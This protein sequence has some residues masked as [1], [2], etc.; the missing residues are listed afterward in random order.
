MKIDQL[1]EKY[2]NSVQTYGESLEIF[3]NPSKREI[4]DVLDQSRHGYRFLI[5]FKTKSFYI[6]SANTYH[7]VVFDE[8]WKEEK[9]PNWTSFWI[10]G[11]GN[12]YVFSGHQDSGGRPDTDFFMQRRTEEDMTALIDQDWSWLTKWIDIDKVRNMIIDYSGLDVDLFG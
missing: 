10:G 12:D 7:Q 4:R 9:L 3:K 2:V 1:V 8:I 11:K 5:N 6:F